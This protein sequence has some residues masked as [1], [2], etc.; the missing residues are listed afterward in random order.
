MYFNDDPGEWIQTEQARQM[1]DWA[2]VH[3]L[4]HEQYDGMAPG[5]GRLVVE[6]GR[7]R[8]CGALIGVVS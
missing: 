1:G 2:R 6:N 8:A 3:I 7:C 4:I 5:S